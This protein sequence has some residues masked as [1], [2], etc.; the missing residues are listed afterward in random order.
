M[1]GRKAGEL[2]RGEEASEAKP[3][4]ECAE[5]ASHEPHPGSWVRTVC[6]VWPLTDGGDSYVHTADRASVFG[7]QRLERRAVTQEPRRIVK[8][9]PGQQDRT[10]SGTRGAFIT[11]EL[12]RAPT[13]LSS[14]IRSWPHGGHSSG[15][16]REKGG[17]S[18]DLGWW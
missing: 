8:L 13:R 2:V 11:I 15:Q 4:K 16:N 9:R 1:A 17:C 6:D 7:W 3:R 5:R 14:G 18:Q 12:T 10:S